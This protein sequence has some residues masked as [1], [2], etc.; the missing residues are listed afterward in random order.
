[1]SRVLLQATSSDSDSEGDGD[2]L[3]AGPSVWLAGDQ[4][5]FA[6]RAIRCPVLDPLSRVAYATLSLAL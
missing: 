4:G 6:F 3:M 5:C 2:T 1:M